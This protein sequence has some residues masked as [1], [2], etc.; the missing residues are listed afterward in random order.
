MTYR[1]IFLCFGE[2]VSTNLKNCEDSQVCFNNYLIA[3]DI[4]EMIRRLKGRFGPCL[5]TQIAGVQANWIYGPTNK[6]LYPFLRILSA[7]AGVLVA[8]QVTE[9]G[10]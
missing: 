7:V 6:Q 1:E 4:I 10:F 9:G 8:A 5:R 2:L 3:S